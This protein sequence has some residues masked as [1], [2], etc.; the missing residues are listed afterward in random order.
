MVVGVETTLEYAVGANDQA[1]ERELGSAPQAAQDIY[2]AKYMR[3]TLEPN[4]SFDIVGENGVIKQLARDMKRTSWQWAV[5]PKRKGE[6]VLRANVQVL[7]PL[8]G[9]KYETVDDY[10]E[11]VKV[12]VKVGNLNGIKQ[13]LSDATTVGGLFTSLFKSWQGALVALAALITA[14]GGVFL[15]IRN[16]GPKGKQRRARIRSK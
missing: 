2:I 3:V 8:G 7:R 1:I 10:T 15:A 13:G 6:Y 11:R 5:K 9:D 4:P 14:L 16:L 12:Q